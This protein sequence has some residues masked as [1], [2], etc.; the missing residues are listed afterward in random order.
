MANDYHYCQTPESLHPLL[1]ALKTTS[2]VV[3]GCEGVDLGREGG[4]ITILSLLL[5]PLEDEQTKPYILDLKTLESDKPSLTLLFDALASGTILKVT[6]DG[7]RDGLALRALGYELAQSRCVLDMQLAMVMKRVEIDGETC[8][9]QIERLRGWLAYRELEQHSQMY[10]LIHKLPSLE[11]ALID[12]FEHDESHENIAEPLRAKTAHGI[13]HSSWGDRP[14][15]IKYLEYAAA[16][17]RLISQLYHRFHDDGMLA[18]LTELQSATTRFLASAGKAEVE[19]YN[20]HRLL[21]LDVLKPRAAGPTYQCDGCR[22]TLGSDAFSKSAR[23]MLNK[24]K[25]RLCWVCRAVKIHEETN[26]NRYD[27]DGDPY[28]YDSDDDPW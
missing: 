17:V 4:S 2:C 8:E 6:F 7:R 11:M 27:S 3:L 15:D 16:V 21:P 19:M 12:I 20:A 5:A 1:E 25:E 23:L 18:R 9:E 22:L 13:Y 14:L 28:A 10:E 24:K 26:R